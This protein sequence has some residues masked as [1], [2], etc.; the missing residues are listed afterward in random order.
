MQ[1]SLHLKGQTP[2]R[3]VKRWVFRR[4]AWA[5]WLSGWRGRGPRVGDGHFR[6]S[7]RSPPQP[8]W[9]PSPRPSRPSR[10]PPAHVRAHPL[11]ENP[12]DRA[13]LS[14]SSRDRRV[15]KRNRFDA[16]V[17]RLTTGVSP[18]PRRGSVRRRRC[19][20]G[21]C[22]EARHR[23][24]DPGREVIPMIITADAPAWLSPFRAGP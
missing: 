7:T 5:V 3:G 1:D 15:R 2:R 17:M 6:P 9:C 19:R 8:P 14:A 13:D 10:P 22:T 16:G 24:H 12:Y 21:R 20:C 4:P 23:G 18:S 11:I